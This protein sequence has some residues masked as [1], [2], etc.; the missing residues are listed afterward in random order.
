[1]LKNSV[2]FIVG[3]HIGKGENMSWQNDP[4]IDSWSGK[5]IL[6]GT[7]SYRLVL[8]AKEQTI[9]SNSQSIRTVSQNCF[10]NRISNLTAPGPAPYIYFSHCCGNDNL[11]ESESNI[12]KT[13]REQN[14]IRTQKICDN[15]KQI[16]NNIS[17]LHERI[18]LLSASTLVTNHARTATQN[19]LNF[20]N[21][22]SSFTMPTQPFCSPIQ[23]VRCNNMNEQNGFLSQ[24][25]G[26]KRGEHPLYLSD[27]RPQKKQEIEASAHLK[28]N[29]TIHSVYSQSMVQ[30]NTSIEP[31]LYGN[32]NSM[33]PLLLPAQNVPF[34]PIEPT[35]SNGT[36]GPKNALKQDLISER[37]RESQIERNL[38]SKQFEYIILEKS[39]EQIS[40][41]IFCQENSIKRLTLENLSLQLHIS[42]LQEY[43]KSLEEAL[44]PPLKEQPT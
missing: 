17:M 21:P 10:Y 14:R 2:F 1:M 25:Q 27:N 18:N 7:S 4:L 24:K 29:G 41:K 37:Y 20:P 30:K 34:S 11:C 44:R 35:L 28:V 43:I 38:Q 9:P 3:A 31:N 40:N 13:R 15:I 39:V 42:Q 12:L 33:M 32:L 19:S 36:F 22:H 6:E 16:E 26:N 8:T 23:L 5:V